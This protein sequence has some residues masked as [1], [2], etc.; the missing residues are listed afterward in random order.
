MYNYYVGVTNASACSETP[1]NWPQGSNNDGDVAGYYYND[2]VNSLLSHAAKYTYDSVNRLTNAVATGNWTYNQTYTYAGDGSNG[3]YGNMDC[4]ASPAEVKCLAP[5][6]SATTNRITTSGYSYDAAGNVTGDGTNTYQWDAEAHLTKVTNGAGTAISTN[7]YNALGQRVRDVTQSATT[8]EAY[9]AGGNLLWRYTGSSST[10]RSFVPFNGG[11][12]AEYYSGGTLFDYTD[13]LGSITTSTSYNGSACQERLFYPY[14]E[15]ATGAGTCAMHQTFAQ[16]PDYDA[17][18]DQYNTLNR[19]YTPSGRWMSP[20]PGGV[21][22]VHLDDPQTWNMYAYVRNNPTTLTDPTGLYLLSPEES[23]N[24]SNGDGMMYVNA[25]DAP[26]SDEKKESASPAQNQ[27]QAQTVVFSDNANPA[28]YQP[29]GTGKAADRTVDYQAAKMDK[30][31]QINSHDI[32]NSANLTL[33][34]KLD[35]SSKTKSVIL[36]DPSRP[37]EGVYKDYQYVPAAGAYR[38]ARDWK[39]DGEPAR[40]YDKATQKAY[41]YEVTTFNAN[42]KVAIKTE[43]TNAPPF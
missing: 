8:D 18:T 28:P 17:E 34:E 42:A 10:N 5:T 20:D 12:L 1:S 11:I 36:A 43:Y 30:N 2:N 22:V 40:V 29:N 9:G 16:L 14:G 23:T 26:S 31:G 19:H 15:A 39:V 4:T 13:E 3:Q 7:T 24:I 37:Q 38:V 41:R 33:H 35:P 25:W 27:Q 32:D 6:Y 21:K